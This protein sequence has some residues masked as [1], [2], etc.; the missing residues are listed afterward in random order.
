M[1]TSEWIQGVK[2]WD[3]HIF[4]GKYNASDEENTG[5][6]LREAYVMTT[7]NDDFSSQMFKW[8]FVH[9]G[10][11]PSNIFV[12]RHPTAKRQIVLV[13][14]GLYVSLTDNMWRQYARFW[15]YLLMGDQKDCTRYQLLGG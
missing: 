2:L 14:H 7:V 6:G 10:P 12:R 9:C 15:K 1:L 11:H 3:K 13:D 4:T 8:G 5:M